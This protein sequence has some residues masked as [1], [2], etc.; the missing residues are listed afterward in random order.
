MII[1]AISDRRDGAFASITHHPIIAA[2]LLPSGGIGA[3][4]FLDQL[5]T[6]F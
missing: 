1:D 4:A 2:I 6:S 3:L 5:A